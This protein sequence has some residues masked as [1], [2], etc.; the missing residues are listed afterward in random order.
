M[1]K[2]PCIETRCSRFAVYRGR[3][4]EHAP[5]RERETH[6]DVRQ[7]RDPAVRHVYSTK[8][9]R[10][11]RRRKL[12][13]NPICEACGEV[14]ATEVDHVKPI[15]D[16]G[17]PYSLANLSSL[18]SPCHGRKTNA[19]VRART[20]GAQ[21]Q[22]LVVIAGRAGVGKTATR[23]ALG[24]L[25]EART[26]GPDDYAGDWSTLLE[27]LD[28]EHG[29]VIV[30]CVRIPRALLAR[31]GTRGGTVVELTATET[32]R[33]ERLLTRGETRERAEAWSTREHAITYREAKCRAD[34]VLETDTLEVDEV[35]QRIAS[36]LDPA[37]VGQA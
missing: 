22:P 4:E 18:C 20:Y 6:R 32:T 10:I 12:T 13:A 14:L 8:R 2:T 25:L 33:R 27:H 28:A 21:G 26:L 3:C 17:R 11:L 7:R 29:T 30:E 34:L 19:E 23:H 15:E 9:W 36:S 35:T 1:P 24:T 37:G 16:G 31:L 5:Q